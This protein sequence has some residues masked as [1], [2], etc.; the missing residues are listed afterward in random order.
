MTDT[1]Q[2]WK[3]SAT[4]SWQTTTCG[5]L[6]AAVAW[7]TAVMAAI[8]GNAATEPDWNIPVVATIAAIGLIRARDNNLK[9]EDAN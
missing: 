1:I 8:D 2:S 7:A 3:N 6:A 4:R 5:V 9:S